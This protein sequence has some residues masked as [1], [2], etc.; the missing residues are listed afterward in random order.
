MSAKNASRVEF[1][2]AF[3]LLEMILAVV[4]ISA[5]AALSLQHLRPSGQVARQRSCDVTRQTLQNYAD[6]YYSREGTWPS[7][8]LREIA[9]PTYAGD[10]LP[11]CPCE[12]GRYQ[13]SGSLII[14]PVHEA[15]RR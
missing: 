2:N 5:V 15:S 3:T 6:R 8:D 1:R 14:C 11:L 10:D 13:M 4:I 7:R 12:G 9:V